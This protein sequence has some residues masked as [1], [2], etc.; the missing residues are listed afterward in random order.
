[1]PSYDV[2]MRHT[3]LPESIWL[4]AG[5]R[6]QNHTPDRFLSAYICYTEYI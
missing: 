2:G 4:D 3:D 5:L 1:M 6:W